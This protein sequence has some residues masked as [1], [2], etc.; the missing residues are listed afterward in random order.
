MWIIALLCSLMTHHN[1][2]LMCLD[3]FSDSQKKV[4]FCYHNT[5]IIKKSI[6]LNVFQCLH[7][8]VGQSKWAVKGFEAIMF[9][10]LP[11]L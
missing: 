1:K 5:T 7:S 11:L 6:Y 9:L 4:V 2:H 10:L 8:I 3:N